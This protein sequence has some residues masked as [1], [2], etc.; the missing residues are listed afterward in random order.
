M[1]NSNND[2]ENLLVETL[3]IIADHDKTADD[4]RWCLWEATPSIW[5]IPTASTFF[6]WDDF[7]E[8]ANV[9]YDSGY[10]GHKVPLGLKIVGD[11]WWLER[12]EYDGSEWWE[13]KTL[14]VRPATYSKPDSII[15]Q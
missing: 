6:T 1:G 13:F 7:A 11:D 2:M 12:H 5:R 14:P 3:E 10:G 15:T 9:T 8:L 4:V